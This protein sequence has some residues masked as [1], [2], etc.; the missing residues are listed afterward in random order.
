M[1]LFFACLLGC[2][3]KDKSEIG[4]RGQPQRSK[5]NAYIDKMAEKY[6]A[7]DYSTKEVHASDLFKPIYTYEVKKSL[8]REDGRPILFSGSVFD[9]VKEKDDYIIM[10]RSFL[11]SLGHG[12][13][14]IF[15]LKCTHEQFDYIR[16]H[17][18]EDTIFIG[19]NFTGAAKLSEVKRLLFKVSAVPDEY[20]DL[21]FLND[22]IWV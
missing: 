14:V 17:T 15:R 9:I 20:S 2:E 13:D 4:E 16:E 6:N 7:F 8:I 3:R 21:I 11:G 5:F 1:V 10:F 12:L 22:I 18:K 19:D